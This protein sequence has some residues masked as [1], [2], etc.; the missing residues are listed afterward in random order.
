MAVRGG[1]TVSD[2]FT[3]ISIEG[4]F[5]TGHRKGVLKRGILAEEGI[6]QNAVYLIRKRSHRGRKGCRETRR[7]L[8]YH[9]FE[10]P[11]KKSQVEISR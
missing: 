1:G 7:G 3:L 11:A 9:K 6:R 8:Y 5:R 2:L 10:R 4:A